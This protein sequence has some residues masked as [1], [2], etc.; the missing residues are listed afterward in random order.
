M[1]FSGSSA[2]QA[3]HTN[4]PG[5]KSTDKRG[6]Q[7]DPHTT[8]TTKTSPFRPSYRNGITTGPPDPGQ[9]TSPGRT[10]DKETPQSVRANV[11]EPIPTRRVEDSN[12]NQGGVTTENPIK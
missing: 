1:S 2:D 8:M 7:L 11:V 9:D 3:H 6:G 12:R 4:R 10:G 5:R